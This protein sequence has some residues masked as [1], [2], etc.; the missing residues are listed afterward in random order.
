VTRILRV[1]VVPAVTHGSRR[2]HGIES[3][4]LSSQWVCDCRDL[5]IPHDDIHIDK[6][7]D[8]HLEKM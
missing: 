2:I 6:E 5:I 8:G 1:Y 4:N 7:I 3:R